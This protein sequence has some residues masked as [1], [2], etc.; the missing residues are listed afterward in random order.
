MPERIA[1]RELRNRSAEI[2]RDVQNGA[3]YEVTNHG[4]VVALISPASASGRQELRIRKARHRGGF[5]SLPRV[6][7]SARMQDSLDELPGDR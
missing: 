7:R 6:E 3:A 2:L 5:T 4:R 1:H